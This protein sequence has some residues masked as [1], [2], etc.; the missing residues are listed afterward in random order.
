[1]KS[2][3]I[4][5]T[6][7]GVGKTYV[8]SLLIKTLREAGINAAGFKPLACGD[9]QD[10]R[11]LRGAGPE[12]LSLEQV[13]PV[14]LRSG[15][16]P[17]IAARLENKP[18]NEVAL[19]A[20]FDELAAQCDCVAVE[21][22][23]GWLTPIGDKRHFGDMAADWGMPVVLVI[24]NRRGA[25]NHALMTLEAIKASGAEC[26]GVIFNSSG[27]EWDTACVTN[28]SVFEEFAPDT[29]VL[30]ELIHGQDY[31]DVEPLLNALA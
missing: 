8:V 7:T 25:L 10:V 2:F 29:P 24:G 1:M 6:D 30:G 12:G 22:V 11:L 28:R 19:K 31:L 20:A 14:Y 5:G 15:A 3:I 4:T 18:V 26:A 27:E 21:G 17:F 16:C 23:G 13:N 9:R